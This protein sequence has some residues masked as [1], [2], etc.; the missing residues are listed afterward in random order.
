MPACGGFQ[1]S[2]NVVGLERFFAPDREIVIAGSVDDWFRHVDYYMTHEAE[3]KGI[4]DAG[5]AR[6]L[7]DHTYHNRVAQV[8]Q[9]YATL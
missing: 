2:A 3:R 8:L 7:A 4:Q 5:T 6:A 1:L 9:I